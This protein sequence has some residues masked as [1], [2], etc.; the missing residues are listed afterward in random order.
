MTYTLMI[1]LNSTLSSVGSF[2]NEAACFEAQKQF[3][4]Q[5]IASVCV[6]QESP[7][8]TMQ[9]MLEMIRM[10]TKEVGSL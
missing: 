2:A 8:K 10:F 1:V 4:K 9:R 6:Q 5:K 3:T 7:E